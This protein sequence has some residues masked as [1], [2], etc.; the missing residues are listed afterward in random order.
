MDLFHY[1]FELDLLEK[2]RTSLSVSNFDDCERVVDWEYR[3]VVLFFWQESF[4]RQSN[5][6]LFPGRSV[7]LDKR[8]EV[9]APSET[10]SKGDLHYFI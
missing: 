2:E 5:N 7:V 1:L 10:I 9:P 8:K 3:A 4:E 6:L